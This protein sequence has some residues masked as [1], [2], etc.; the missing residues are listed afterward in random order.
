MNNRYIRKAFLTLMA[1]LT[2]AAGAARPVDSATARRV[3]E[4]Y[5]QLHGMRN[6][7]ALAD[8][9]AATPFTAFYVFAALGGGFVLVSGDDCAVPVLGWSATARFDAKAIPAHVQWWLDGYER[10]LEGIRNAESGV[11]NVEWDLLA[12]GTAPEPPLATAVAPLMTTGWNQSPYYNNLCPYDYTLNARSVTGC[13]ATATAQVMKFW[14][15]PATGHGNHTYTSQATVGGV[16]FT[17][18]DLSANF[19][20]TTYQWNLMPDTLNAISSPAQV[21]AVATLMYH[22]GVADEMGYSPW[23]SSAHNCNYGSIIPSSETSLQKYFKYRSDMASLHRDDYSSSEWNAMLRDELDAG[24][25]I[26]FSGRDNSGG[27]SFVCDGYNN[28]GLFHINWGWGGAYDGDFMMGALNPTGGGTGSNDDGTYN[29]DNVALIRIR[30]NTDWNT[31][32]TTTVTAEAVGGAGCTVNGTGSYPFGEE[33]SLYARAA[34]GYRFT[35]WSDGCKFNPR[36]FV[37]NGGS[38]HFT[39]QFAPLDDDTITY[40]PGN[41]HLTRW[42]IMGDV[43]VWGIRIPASALADG[44][45]LKAV[46]FY[47][48]ET[49]NHTITV[50]G[51]T[52]YPTTTLRTITHHVHQT[53]WQTVETGLASVPDGNDVWVM[54]SHNGGYPAAVTYGCGNGYGRIWGSNYSTLD[55]PEHTFMVKALFSP[56]ADCRVTAYPYSMGFGDNDLETLERC[57]TLL[58]ADG[59]GYGWDAQTFPGVMGSASYINDIGLLTP[60]NWLISPQMLLLPGASYE[61]SWVAGAFDSN[62]Y[63]EH[64][65][66]FVSTTGTLP[67]DFTLVQE[68][69][70]DSVQETAMSLDLSAYAGQ[71]IHIAFRHW[72]STDVF[73]MYIDDVTVRQTSDPL[74]DPY[75]VYVASNN[76]AWGTVSGGGSYYEGDTAVLFADS[77]IGYRFVEWQDGNRENPRLVIVTCDSTFTATFG[78]ANGIG[79]VEGEGIGLWPNPVAGEVTLVGL[80]APATVVLVDA[81]G[82]EAGHWHLAAGQNT[83]GLNAVPAG[84]YLLRIV[85]GDTATVR[86][87]VVKGL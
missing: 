38:V 76:S 39:A 8:V 19:G 4:V 53:G 27:H 64:Y 68:Y 35:G 78:R 43:T 7:G 36:V 33:V 34:V 37:V 61:L 62:Y 59:D 17:Y 15:H 54:L 49:G 31:E 23:E 69:T 18:P 42:G 74:P 24:R 48:S 44:V 56:L 73:W 21:N 32:G 57:W 70:L 66:V 9:T 2:A 14:N 50:Y 40:C 22:V 6:T 51:G 45:A 72:N 46:Q 20:N 13:V 71:N 41:R 87:L 82:R 47:A 77:F 16:T 67:S 63:A 83:L 5:L 86:R 28:S 84:V 81:S 3:A 1:V 29:I 30:P 11:R 52:F 58:D 85:T 60:D 12:A 25:P 75:T 26:L 80:T 79:E 65:G 10:E 55:H